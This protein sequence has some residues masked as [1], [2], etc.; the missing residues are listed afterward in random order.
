MSTDGEGNFLFQAA[1]RVTVP[2]P[3]LEGEN[4]TKNRP[5]PAYKD[6]AG[7]PLGDGR[8]ESVTVEIG[9]YRL[10]GSAPTITSTVNMHQPSPPLSLTPV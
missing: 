10:K 3:I 2:T 7:P 1:D 8:P 5:R 4:H 9:G 6:R